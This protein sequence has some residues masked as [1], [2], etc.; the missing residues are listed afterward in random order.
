MDEHMA[1]VKQG[2]GLMASRGVAFRN[3]DDICRFADLICKSSFVP[4]AMQ[5]KSGDVV[6]AIAYGL[7]L[8]L[9]PMAALQNIAVING[10]PSVFGD[11]QL[12]LVLNDPECEYVHEREPDEVKEK[13]EGRCEAKRKG[14][15]PV[16]RTFSI[17]DARKADL[18]SKPGPWKS[19]PHRM[20]QMRARSWCL[21]DAFP[22][23]L[24]GL[25]AREEAQD[26]EL[27]DVT[28]SGRPS[29]PLE[30][31]ERRPTKDEIDSLL[32][33]A[34]SCDAI[35]ADQ[36]RLNPDYTY[37]PAV[38]FFQGMFD[39]GPET[40]L[41]KKFYREHMTMQQYKA[42]QGYFDGIIKILVESE[43]QVPEFDG[44][45]VSPQDATG[46]EPIPEAVASERAAEPPPGATLKPVS[47][48]KSTYATAEQMQALRQMAKKVSQRAYDDLMESLQHYPQGYPMGTYTD[49]EARLQAQLA[50]APAEAS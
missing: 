15:D 27:I 41:A 30:P 35:Q 1:V 31:E 3:L 19:Y 11:M 13:E 34:A 23:T 40:K 48:G 6:A 7:E 5:G 36:K 16:V 43:E 9:S 33:Q 2:D 32:S 25:Y 21:R 17:A 42:A 44:T 50:E 22:H 38:E 37:T 39:V 24:K 46:D 20:L 10:K 26:I 18:L 28:P 45:P 8:G 12:A 47:Q 49:V 29:V 14:H 4:S